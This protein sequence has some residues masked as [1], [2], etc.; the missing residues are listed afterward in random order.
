MSEISVERGV[1]EAAVALDG[2][3]PGWHKL[4]DTKTLDMNRADL[5]VLGQVFA[6]ESL[7]A[8]TGYGFGMIHHGDVFDQSF[9]GLDDGQVFDMVVYVGGGKIVHTKPYWLDEIAVR[10]FRDKVAARVDASGTLSS[11]RR[12]GKTL[13]SRAWARLTGAVSR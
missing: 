1:A 3:K 12:A 7:L 9:G 13:L 2:L 4:V 10:E 6:D 8:L 5:C 11:P